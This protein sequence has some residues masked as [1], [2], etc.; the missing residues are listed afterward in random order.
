MTSSALWSENSS[1]ATISS[2]G[3]LS[4]SSV[5]SDQYCT[6]TASYSGKSDSHTITIKNGAATGRYVDNN[7]GTVTDT[8]TG[9][10]WEKSD[11]GLGDTL[12]DGGAEWAGANEY[13]NNLVMGI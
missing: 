6:I 1:Y 13:C 4:T 7:N 5:G 9:L 12:F 8:Q 3:Y 10:I 2:G 11:N